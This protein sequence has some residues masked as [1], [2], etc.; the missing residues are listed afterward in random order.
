MDINSFI[1]YIE[2]EKRFSPHTIRAYKRDLKQFIDFINPHEYL[3]YPTFQIIR[4]WIMFLVDQK[5]KPQSVNRKLSTLRSCFKFLQANKFISENPF[6]QVF[7]LKT[8][9]SLPVIFDKELINSFLNNEIFSTD[10]IGQRDSIAIEILYSTGIRVS[11]LIALQNDDF[12]NLNYYIKVVGKGTKERIIPISKKLVDKINNFIALK[13]L[14][15]KTDC[16]F[17]LTTIKGKK[18]YPYLVQRIVKKYLPYLTTNFHNS[19]HT[20]RHS[21]ATHLLN[22]GADLNSVKELLGHSS[23]ASTQL[24]THNTI[25][26]LLQIYKLAH[27]RA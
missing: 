14:C 9:K 26:Q 4:E 18:A 19:A 27:P 25:E 13:N 20:L 11:E 8:R 2:T 12:N 7:F 23:I 16:S 5:L 17:L 24:Y 22:N 10:F 6:E 3:R 21:F 15:I 1:R